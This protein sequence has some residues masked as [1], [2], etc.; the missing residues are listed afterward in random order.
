MNMKRQ[1]LTLIYKDLVQTCMFSIT[2]FIDIFR[3]NPA[4]TLHVVCWHNLVPTLF[5]RDNIAAGLYKCILFKKCGDR[6]VFCSYVK[7]TKH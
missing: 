6:V 3:G 5:F 1:D 2:C 7:C 4:R